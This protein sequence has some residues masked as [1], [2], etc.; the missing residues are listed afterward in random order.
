MT[1]RRPIG[2]RRR[3]FTLLELMLALTLTAIAAGT[4]GVALSAARHASTRVAEHR[5]V[6][7]ADTR[8]RSLLAD[9]LRHAPAAEQV[10]E[11]L[12]TISRDVAGTTLQFLSQGVR[13]PFGTGPVWRVQLRQERAGLLLHA[14]VLADDA[15]E[16]PVIMQLE[17]ATA[18]DVVVLERA[19][20]FEAASWRA[21]WP[22]AQ[23]RP[24]AVGVSWSTTMP[25]ATNQ[26]RDFVVALDPLAAERP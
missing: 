13:P 6:G 12:L 22:V 17:G 21:D 18:F 23:S 4:A 8:F 26:A 9:M 19:R 11:P 15:R 20:G 16:V 14:S 2:S 7:E 5:R 25:R 10:S 1:A 3:G 24:T